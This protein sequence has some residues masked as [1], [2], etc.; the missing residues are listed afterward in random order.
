MRNKFFYTVGGTLPPNAPSYIERAADDELLQQVQSGKFCYVLTTRQMGKSS[1][2]VRVANQVRRSGTLTA[3]VDLSAFGSDPKSVTVDQW[4]YGIAE[5]IFRELGLRQE[6]DWWGQY[7]LLPPVLRLVHFFRDI[8]LGMTLNRV[9]VF[10]D[11]IDSVLNLPFANDFFAAV[12]ACYNAR[13]EDDR[14][15]RLTFA[16]LGV[17]SPS[18]LIADPNRTPFN[19]GTRINLTD[20]TLAEARPLA[21][22]LADDPLEREAA[23]KRVIEWTG[24][25]PYLTQRVCQI[26]AEWLHDL[27]RDEFRRLSPETVDRIVERQFLSAGA[28]LREENLKFVRVRV[29]RHGKLTLPMLRVYRRV[30]RDEKV[31]DDTTSPAHSELKL[32]GVLKTH[33]DGMLAVRN[34][35]YARVFDIRWLREVWPDATTKKA[36]VR[37]YVKTLKLALEDFNLARNAYDALRRMP[38]LRARADRLWGEFCRRRGDWALELD[39]R[40]GRASDA[41]RLVYDASTQLC[42]LPEF[43]HD[44]ANLLDDFFVQR[45]TQA[46]NPEWRA[47]SILAWLRTRSAI[48]SFKAPSLPASRLIDD[49]LAEALNLERSALK[50]TVAE[51]RTVVFSP[52]GRCLAK[53]G[54]DGSIPVWDISISSR[55]PRL[56]HWRHSWICALA[57]S[58]DGAQLAAGGSHGRIGIWDLGL[59]DSPINTLSGNSDPIHALAFSTD[60]R[61]L[62]ASGELGTVRIWELDRLADQPTVLP[63]AG[64]AVLT[65]AFN[66]DGTRLAAGGE[67][68]V[69]RVWNIEANSKSKSCVATYPRTVSESHK[70]VTLPPEQVSNRHEPPRVLHGGTDWVYSLAFSPDGRRLGVGDGGKAVRIWNMWEPVDVFVLLMPSVKDVSGV[71][72]DGKNLLIVAAVNNLLY[73]RIFDPN[74]KRVVDI[75]EIRL[76]GQRRQFDDLR[77][78][79]GGLWPPH[80]LTAIEH[81]RVM[82]AVSSIIL[83]TQTYAS[84]ELTLQGSDGWISTLAFS[85]DERWLATGSCFGEVRLWDLGQP[86][87]PPVVLRESGD[88]VRDLTFSLDSRAVLARGEHGRMWACDTGAYFIPNLD[89]QRSGCTIPVLIPNSDGYE[90]GDA[91]VSGVLLNNADRAKGQRL[92]LVVEREP[93]HALALSLDGRRL[94]A[95]GIFGGVRAWDLG[96]PSEPPVRIGRMRDE[97]SALAVSTDGRSVA[98]GDGKGCLWV[99]NLETPESTPLEL[100]VRTGAVCSLAISHNGG[101]LVAGDSTGHVIVWKLNEPHDLPLEFV[102]TKSGVYAL[103]ISRD[104]R[105]LASGDTAGC[106]RAWALDTSDRKPR[107]L[108]PNGEPVHAMAFSPD[109]KRLAA[110]DSEGFVNVWDLSSAND[111]P[112]AVRN[113]VNGISA[114]SFSPNGKAL[115]LMTSHH[116]HRDQ[117]ITSRYDVDLM[118]SLEHVTEMPT[119]GD[120]LLIVATVNEFFH[121]RIFDVNGKMVVDIDEKRL[122][123][124]STRIDALR[125]QLGSLWPPHVLTENEKVL[126]VAAVTSIV[127][128]TQSLPAV[129]SCSLPG[130]APFSAASTFCFLDSSGQRVRV[131]VLPTLESVLVTDLSL[132]INGESSQSSQLE[133]LPRQNS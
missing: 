126:V 77:G 62:A 14:F 13:A 101:L 9:L 68:G 105:R 104:G 116:V 28:D 58:P 4:Y 83:Q 88:P 71:P 93:I 31:V 119:R 51:A 120:G 124:Q 129:V 17:A 91:D 102:G 32:A 86:I 114:I 29:T 43:A 81:L 123:R 24:G 130:I 27:S 66:V 50:Q 122:A 133:Q 110:D 87:R 108:R 30:L 117:N 64:G 26:A 49:L 18:D 72:A 10:V 56:F 78:Q 94:V 59:S 15:N 53:R 82:R 21:S 79:L 128:Y 95:G 46:T 38:S 99:W 113:N 11:E 36:V 8:V 67:Y 85:P 112:F 54:G 61:R 1:L 127:S 60:G 57:F 63:G 37:Q 65:L 109:G 12:R 19:I 25:H 41:L 44:A 52:D 115:I 7:A 100:S 80:E 40:P 76:P 48:D 34:Q 118:S 23:L 6:L 89:R 125:K 35:I 111:R 97:I 75:D 98:A 121:F 45:A 73:L 103:A 132:G 131:A 107:V 90:L 16:L 33:D 47:A 96:S 55:D 70:P 22:G 42:K 69:V 106:V 2:M 39:R 3:I 84:P 92:M 20:F 5:R 74:G